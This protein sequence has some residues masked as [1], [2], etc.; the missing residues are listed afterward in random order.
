MGKVILIHANCHNPTAKGDFAFAGNIAKDII[1]EL[2]KQSIHDIDVVLVSALDGIPRFES[3]YG[4]AVDGR[5]T[6]EGT[7]IGLSSLETFDAVENTVIAFIDA[8][9][10]KH[11]AGDLV[12]RVLSP[13]SKF[14]FVG[15]VNQQ[16]FSDVFM[17]TLYRMQAQKEQPGVYEPFNADD[18][19]IGSA[20]LGSERLGLPTITKAEDLP[21]LSSSEMA[22]L[23]TLPKSDYGFMYLAAVDSSKDYKLIAQYIKLSGH[24]QYVLVG[25]FSSNKYEIKYAYEHDMTLVTSKTSLPQIEYHA[26]L[27]NPVMRKMVANA[28]GSLVLSTGVTSTL[29]AMRD[30]KLTYYQDMSNNTEFVAAYLIAVKSIVSSDSSLF[31]AMPQMIIDLSDLLFANKPL[32]K[33]KMERTRDLLQLSS[34]SSRLIST[35]LTIIEQASGKIATR[36]LTFIGGSRKTN[37]HVQL[38]TVC[39][40]LRKSGEMG[41]PVHDQALRRAA[42]WGRLFEL[43]VLIKSMSSSDLNKTDPTYGRSALHWAVSSKNLDCAR[44]LVK[45]GASLDLQDKDGQTALHKAVKNGDRAMIKMLIAAGASVDIADKSSNSPKDCAPDSGILLFIKDCH[46]AQ[47]NPTCFS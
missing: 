34:I 41:S 23:S 10:C 11:S 24:D 12:K 17:Q 7:S 14:L 18:T 22:K 28:T 40:S 6:V 15:N 35:N 46:A 39:A 47:M 5:V 27:P 38:A 36:L 44:A 19:L 2:E 42:T 8:N 37:D 26:S 21:T 1:R 30:S 4:A 16:A 25:N 29:E 45:A 43:K 33:D 32:S 3:M 31:G 13:D 20:G 9:R